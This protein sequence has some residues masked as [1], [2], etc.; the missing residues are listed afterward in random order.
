MN[1]FFNFFRRGH[2]ECAICFEVINVRNC[3]NLECGHKFHTN[4]LMA[5]CVSGNISCPLCRRNILHQQHSSNPTEETNHVRRTI[6]NIT[7]DTNHVRRTIENITEEELKNLSILEK[8]TRLERILESN[9]NI[10]STEERM[11]LSAFILHLKL[12]C[13]RIDLDD[14]YSHCAKYDSK[15]PLAHEPTL[16]L[17][18]LKT[19]LTEMAANYR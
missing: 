7:E 2:I 16:I 6:E 15:Y 10:T 5:S 4:C 14:F 9:S 12:I 18:H 11:D 8:I 19:Q 17:F 13:N 3:S 1:N